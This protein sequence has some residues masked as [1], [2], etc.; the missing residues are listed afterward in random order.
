MIVFRSREDGVRLNGGFIHL[1]MKTMR[2]QGMR[3]WWSSALAILE[4]ELLLVTYPCITASYIPIASGP[5]TDQTR[6]RRSKRRE[7]SESL[8]PVPDSD[9]G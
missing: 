4:Y 2:V 5:G 7:R 6:P 9:P 8:D 3:D 1:G